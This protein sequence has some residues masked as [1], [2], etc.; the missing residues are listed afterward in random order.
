MSSPLCCINSSQQILCDQTGLF[1]GKYYLSVSK[2]TLFFKKEVA[3]GTG[4]GANPGP[5][6]FIYFLIFLPF[7]AEP[8]RLPLSKKTF[9]NLITM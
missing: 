9:K 3:R 2:K 4:W 6:D 8:Q 7:T 5:L 1:C